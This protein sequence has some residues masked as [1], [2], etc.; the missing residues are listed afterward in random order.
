MRRNSLYVV[1]L[2]RNPKAEIS[3]FQLTLQH[4]TDIEPCVADKC[5]RSSVVV[6]NTRDF[7]FTDVDSRRAYR[8]CVSA[9]DGEHIPGRRHCV[10]AKPRSL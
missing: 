9:L 8:V 4:A 5:I 3:A 10:T 6:Y 1:W 7:T 2:V